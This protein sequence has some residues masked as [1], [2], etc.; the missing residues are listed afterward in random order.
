M[1]A[2]VMRKHRLAVKRYP[3]I[4][5]AM[6]VFALLAMVSGGPA[7]L[8]SAMIDNHAPVKGGAILSAGI[9]ASFWESVP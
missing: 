1:I 6:L 9:A 8:F 4:R 2:S 7:G 3:Q 5:T